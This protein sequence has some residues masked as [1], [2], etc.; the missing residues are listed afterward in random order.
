[1]VS[2]PACTKMRTPPLLAK[3]DHVFSTVPYQTHASGQ[4]AQTCK[5]VSLINLL[6][7]PNMF[8]RYQYELMDVVGNPCLSCSQKNINCGLVSI[9]QT[10]REIERAREDINMK[11]RRKREKWRCLGSKRETNQSLARL[12]AWTLRIES[13]ESALMLSGT[14]TCISTCLLVLSHCIYTLPGSYLLMNF[15]STQKLT[16]KCQTPMD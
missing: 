5:H 14:P 4:R 16:A 13:L 2:S 9:A 8:T 7:W 10:M 3:H 15:A 1:M 6:Y 11:G 12:R